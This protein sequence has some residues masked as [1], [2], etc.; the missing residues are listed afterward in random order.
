L[1]KYNLIEHAKVLWHNIQQGQ[2]L[3][4]DQMMEFKTLDALRTK[5]M[6]EAEKHC[7]KL[8]MGAVEWSPELTLARHQI[9]AW[10]ALLCT[11]KGIKINSC[12]VCRLV[13]KTN[14]SL[15]KGLSTDTITTNLK[16]AYKDYSN[17]KKQASYLCDTFLE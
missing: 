3:S 12:L 17:L 6:N 11:H 4:V 13:K 14:I 1:Q 15:P 7:R 5:G 16:A 2:P 9:A 10:T 8:K